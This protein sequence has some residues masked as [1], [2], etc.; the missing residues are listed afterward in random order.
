MSILY[1]Q[2][3]STDTH[4]TASLYYVQVQPYDRAGVDTMKCFECGSLCITAYWNENVLA[5]DSR[6]NVT[7]VSK[8]CT[9][10]N[11]ESYKTKLPEKIV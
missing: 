11:W 8:L 1:A 4:N 9:H 2:T 7:H 6:T 3:S 10:C 5:I